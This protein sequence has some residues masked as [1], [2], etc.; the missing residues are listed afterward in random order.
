MCVCADPKCFTVQKNLCRDGLLPCDDVWCLPPFRIQ[1]DWTT[2]SFPSWVFI[3][4]L[5]RHLSAFK[6]KLITDC[7]EKKK[8]VIFVNRI[9][10]P[11]PVLLE[12]CRKFPTTMMQPDEAHLL[13]TCDISERMV[14]P[15]NTVVSIKRYA[16]TILP[17][18]MHEVFLKKSQLMKHDVRQSSLKPMSLR[19]DT[20][21]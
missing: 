13:A 14:E 2:S 17:P 4:G 6:E 21:R 20:V 8:A 12:R 9:H 15:I 1:F 3:L 19:N 5:S 7:F 11:R 16:K 10:F 18:P